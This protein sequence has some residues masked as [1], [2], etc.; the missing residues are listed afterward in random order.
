MCNYPGFDP[1]NYAKS[2]PKNYVNDIIFTP[3]EPVLFLRQLR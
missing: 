1:N 3:Y 2:D